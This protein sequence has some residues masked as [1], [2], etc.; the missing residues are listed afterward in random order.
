MGAGAHGGVVEQPL[1]DVPDLLDVERAERED[2]RLC[3]L[4]G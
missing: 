3:P 1:V 4:R 2:A